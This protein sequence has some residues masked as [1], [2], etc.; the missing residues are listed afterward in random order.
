MLIAPTKNPV[1]PPKA[2][3]DKMTSAATGL[4]PGSINSAARPA[5]A[6]A[7]SAAMSTSSRALGLRPSKI[8]ANGAMHS[9]STRM[10]TAP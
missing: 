8:R 6:S 10:E 2:T 5:T 3:P 1:S 9:R 7:Q 4:N